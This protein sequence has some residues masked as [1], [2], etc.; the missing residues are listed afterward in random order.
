MA[1]DYNT[2]LRMYIAVDLGLISSFNTWYGRSYMYIVICT[3]T[4][5]VA[6]AVKTVAQGGVRVEGKTWFD[7][8]S[9][10]MWQQA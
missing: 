5:D 10:G 4:K 8:Q 1:H 3:G 6:K 7:Q 2:Q 9:E